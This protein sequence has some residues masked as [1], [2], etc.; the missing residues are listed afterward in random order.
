[1]R[2]SKRS[3]TEDT[4]HG[5]RNSAVDV[6]CTYSDY[7]IARHVFAP[8]GSDHDRAR[9]RFASGVQ[10]TCERFS[11]IAAEERLAEHFDDP[12]G[13]RQFAQLRATVAAHK[14]D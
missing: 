8:L 11:D 13:L 2:L 5:P 1:M 12:G 14:Y 4:N 9:T 3:I 7:S 6:R 10:C